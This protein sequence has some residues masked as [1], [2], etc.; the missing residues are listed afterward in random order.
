MRGPARHSPIASVMPL[1]LTHP[2]PR[3]LPSR[4][5][6][7]VLVLGLQPLASLRV[8]RYLHPKPINWIAS[9]FLSCYY[10]SDAGTKQE[11]YT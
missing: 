6:H 7:W 2:P 9:F 1:A 3:G 4:Y 5:T 10:L 8:L 11:V